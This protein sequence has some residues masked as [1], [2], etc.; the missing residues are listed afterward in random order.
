MKSFKYIDIM[1]GYIF[2]KIRI[3][4]FMKNV[5]EIVHL[6]YT[7]ITKFHTPCYTNL[8]ENSSEFPGTNVYN[9]VIERGDTLEQLNIN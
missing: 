8:T 6:R 5:L 2:L 7:K 3:W 4:F 1:K 9:R